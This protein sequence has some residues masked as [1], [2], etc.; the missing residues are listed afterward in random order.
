MLRGG[1]F[2]AA[3]FGVDPTR[4]ANPRQADKFEVLAHKSAHRY[5]VRCGAPVVV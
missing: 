4:V 2:A 3:V 5:V 1:H